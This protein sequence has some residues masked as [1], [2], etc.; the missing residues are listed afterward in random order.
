MDNQHTTLSTV[1]ARTIL[2]VKR[3]K[4]LHANQT[5]ATHAART[6]ITAHVISAA[7]VRRCAEPNL[8]RGF[9]RKRARL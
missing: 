7:L 8:R 2:A 3:C 9:D 6:A 4:T 5:A 1:S